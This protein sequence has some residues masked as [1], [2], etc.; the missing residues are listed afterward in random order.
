MKT[1]FVAF[2]DTE[3]DD[4]K[5]CRHYESE[6]AGGMIAGKTMAHIS[7]AVA[8]TNTP[9]ARA[10]ADAIEKAAKMIAKKRVAA[11]DKK[12]KTRDK[13]PIP[14]APPE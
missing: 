9:E 7:A 3:F 11:G 10:L 4:A 1:I 13:A 14:P 12:R 8:Y 5:E 2:D 6:N